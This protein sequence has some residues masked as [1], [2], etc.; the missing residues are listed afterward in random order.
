[1]ACRQVAVGA[2]GGF[3]TSLLEV[4]ED[5]DLAE[6]VSIHLLIAPVANSWLSGAVVRLEVSAAYAKN[7]QTVPH[8]AEVTH[9]HTVPDSWQQGS[10]EIVLV[11]DGSARTFAPNTFDAG[12]KQ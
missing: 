5:M 10:V 3:H 8:Y 6:P 1:M 11:D 9:D 2:D 12:D 7:A 4:P